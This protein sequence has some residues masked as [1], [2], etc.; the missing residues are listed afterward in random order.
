MKSKQ[1]II[2]FIFALILTSCE[3]EIPFNEK[4]NP[5]K[6]VLNAMI[7]TNNDENHIFVSKTG[8]YDIDSVRD[9]TVYIYVNDVLKEQLTEFLLP[10]P[11]VIDGVDGIYT[12]ESPEP[13]LR[14]KRFTTKLRFN[15]GDKV[16]IEVTGEDNK[17]HAWA[18]DIAPQPAEVEQ[19]D[20]TTID[21]YKTRLNITFTD[22]PNEKN[23]YRLAMVHKSTTY[24][25]TIDGS[26][27]DSSS[28]TDIISID[29][30]EDIVLNEGKVITGEELFPQIE[31]VYAIFDDTRL[32]GTYTMK[33]SFHNGYFLWRHLDPPPGVVVERAVACLEVHLMSITEMQ[34]YYIKALNILKSDSYDEYLSAPIA[35]PSNVEGGVGIVGF[36]S[37]TVKTFMYDSYP[38]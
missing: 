5:P 30:S 2:S 14:R 13:Y 1:I 27:R 12:S 11:I 18:E 6:I 28:F 31:N 3:N 25:K 26:E 34:Y 4:I 16:K 29:T 36:S 17:Y 21:S 9:V 7:N 33:T 23:F 38:E 20:T 22:N 8:N 37:G 24:F 10:K 32:N 19:I 15:P 35:I